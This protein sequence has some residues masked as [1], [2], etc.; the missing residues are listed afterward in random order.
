MSYS[1]K[2]ERDN[3]VMKYLCLACGD[4]AGWEDLSEEEQQAYMEKCR[5]YDEVLAGQDA[6][7]LYAGL[8]EGGAIVKTRGGERVVTDGPF[9]ESKEMGGVFIVEAA[10]LDEAVEVA[11]LHPAAKMGEELGWYVAVRPLFIPELVSIGT[12]A[13]AAAPAG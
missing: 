8:L 13:G 9:I 4:G 2:S 10:S 5:T 11:A 12:K 6:V 7:G 1:T 3:K